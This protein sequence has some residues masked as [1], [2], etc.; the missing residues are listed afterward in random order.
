M[1]RR[2][3]VAALA[4]TG[5]VALP[6]HAQAPTQ[7]VVVSRMTVTVDKVERS[8]RGLWCRDQN[9]IVHAIT[10]KPDVAL[11]DELV[12]GDR[13]DVDYIDAVVVAV[14]P[15]ASLTTL[16][17]T[18]AEARARVIDPLVTVQ[19]QFTLVVT[20]D[21]IDEKAG[22][23]VYHGKDTRRVLRAVRDRRLLRDLRPGDVV[24]VQMTRETAVRVTRA[25]G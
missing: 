21:E 18:T 6:V 25:S 2:L 8:T 1:A 7:S 16:E 4:A 12:E 17:D 13:I 24:K 19:Q 15:G 10:V 14:E 5:L 9:G 20:I 23:V 3:L 22:T 11:F